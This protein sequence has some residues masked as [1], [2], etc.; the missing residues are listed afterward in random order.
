MTTFVVP[1]HPVE[2]NLGNYFPLAEFPTE[3]SPGLSD[4]R[5]RSGRV[6]PGNSG[7]RLGF[8]IPDRVVLEQLDRLEG[9]DDPSPIEG[10]STEGGS[11]LLT[12]GPGSPRRGA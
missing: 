5:R 8:A 9:P 11:P 1:A 10:P 4:L 12:S 2:G 6:S 3:T 7:S